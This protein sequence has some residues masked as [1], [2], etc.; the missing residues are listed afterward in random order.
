MPGASDLAAYSITPIR[1]HMTATLLEGRLPT[2]GDEVALGVQSLADAHVQ[3]GE[4]LRVQ[5][6]DGDRAT[7]LVTGTVVLPPS[8][9][10][11]HELDIG[12]VTT[13]ATLRRISGAD[14]VDRGSRPALPA[15][16][17]RF[18]RSSGR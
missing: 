16:A 2:A 15:R 6:L 11:E 14:N 18:P 1:G 17:R 13:R 12:A 5:G 4:R 8:A 3:I 7:L 10:D 9:G